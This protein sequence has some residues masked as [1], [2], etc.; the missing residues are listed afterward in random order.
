MG[1]GYYE[2]KIKWPKY[3]Q[4]LIFIKIKKPYEKSL[5]QVIKVFL[6]ILKEQNLNQNKLLMYYDYSVVWDSQ[7][8][9][10]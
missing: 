8:C 1:V 2:R 10:L 3:L 9:I 4:N 7:C 5:D 6:E